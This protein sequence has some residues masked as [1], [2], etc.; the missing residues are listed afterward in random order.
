MHIILLNYKLYH[1][2]EY[3]KVDKK[4]DR[5]KKLIIHNSNT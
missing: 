2:R 1:K 4:T 5:V 3:D